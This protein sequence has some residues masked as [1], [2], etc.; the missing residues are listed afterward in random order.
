MLLSN[1]K[2]VVIR[3]ITEIGISIIISVVIFILIYI[4]HR[5]IIVPEICKKSAEKCRKEKHVVKAEIH[6]ILEHSE[7]NGSAKRAGVYQYQ[8]QIDGHKYYRTIKKYY[9]NDKYPVQPLLFYRKK[10]NMATIEEYCGSMETEQG[11]IF[12][13]IFI[14][15]LLS[16]CIIM[17][18]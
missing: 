9:E 1:I 7:K 17:N 10:P 18:L 3:G 4:I 15:T 12:L 13:V 5:Y 6:R 8:Y 14:I 2:Y 16:V 11:M